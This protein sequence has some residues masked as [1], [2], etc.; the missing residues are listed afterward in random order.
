M[1]MGKQANYYPSESIGHTVSLRKRLLAWLSEWRWMDEDESTEEGGGEGKAWSL[2]LLVLLIVTAYSLVYLSLFWQ[3][4]SEESAFA[5]G[6]AKFVYR[7]YYSSRSVL[8]EPLIG[9]G[10]P[11]MADPQVMNFYPLAV[12]FRAISNS[13]PWF[14]MC[15]YVL[16]SSFTLGYV[17]RLTKK[18]YC[19]LC[20]GTGFW[21]GGF[22]DF[23]FGSHFHYSFV[24]LVAIDGLVCRRA[25][26]PCRCVMGCI[27]RILGRM[28]YSRGASSNCFL[29]SEHG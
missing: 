13:W 21:P 10:F 29:L 16:A 23:P 2:A 15:A 28:L 24:L 5:S 18:R 14:V 22:H 19:K 1:N 6:D 4:F 9:G 27:A 25:E 26:T 12:G 17:Y 20:W 8:W 3:G 11:V 7:P